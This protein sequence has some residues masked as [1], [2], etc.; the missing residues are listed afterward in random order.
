[1]WAWMPTSSTD[2]SARS[3]A[4]ASSAAP[5]AKPNPNFES[6]CPVRTNSWV[7]ASTPGVTRTSTA[8]PGV[9][10]PRPLTRPPRRSI[11]SK[12]STTI[13]PTPVSTARASSASD[14]LLPCMTIRAGGTPARRATYSSP[15]VETS[16]HIP[17]S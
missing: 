9:A 17:A 3:R 4:T 2:G 5:E 13:L 7:W 16:R 10:P 8:G 15:P 11:S 1:M 6:S 14:L 12:E